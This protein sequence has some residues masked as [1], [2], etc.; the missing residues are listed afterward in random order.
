M[1]F[2]SNLKRKSIVNSNPFK[3]SHDNTAFQKQHEVEFSLEIT[4]CDPKILK[5]K[6]QRHMGHIHFN[7]EAVN[8]FTVREGGIFGNCV[9]GEDGVWILII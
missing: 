6:T 1:R 7:E 3:K 9:T 2:N 5:V 8:I 4:Q